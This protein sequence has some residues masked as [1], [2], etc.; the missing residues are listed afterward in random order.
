MKNITIPKRFGYPTVD[1]TINGK[2][3]T[4]QS[5]VEITVDDA[6]AEA[7]ENAIALEPKPKRYL[8]RLA[9][10]VEGSILEIKESDLDG[11]KNILPYAFY[12]CDSLT[13]IA[14]PNGVNSIGGYTFADCENL[15]RV[16]LPESITSIDGRAFT[17]SH[18]LTRVS[19]KALTP[20]TLR[21]SSYIP[22]TCIFEVPAESLATYKSA[23]EWSNIANQIVAIEE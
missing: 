9:Q 21:T 17:E 12:N 6:I 22:T 1:I 23:S 8:S 4:F 5:G 19:L 7:I 11:I 15:A 13:N 2:E 16:V 10:L 20:P 18:N 3:E 14:I